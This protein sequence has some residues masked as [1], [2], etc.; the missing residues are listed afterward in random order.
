MMHH[1]GNGIAAW[2]CMAGNETGSLVLID[3]VTADKSGKMN[4]EVHSIVVR[5]HSVKMQQN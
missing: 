1:D 4:S 2:V 5:S 3:Y